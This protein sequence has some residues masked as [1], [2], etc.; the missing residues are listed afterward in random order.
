MVYLYPLTEYREGK[1]KFFRIVILAASFALAS[2]ASHEPKPPKTQEFFNTL[3]K[4]DGTKQFSYAM[5]MEMPDGG[6]QHE[7]GR[8]GGPRGGHGGH[9]GGPPP[10]GGSHDHPKGDKHL[11]E[12]NS[13]D[14][15]LNFTFNESL[16]AKLSDTGFCQQGYKQLDKRSRRG[17]IQLTGECNDMATD[18][19][20]I[21]FPNPPPVKVKEEVIQ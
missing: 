15:H 9:F 4:R 21:K 3:I 2:C 1:V 16:L 14:D 13:M 12:E 6:E 20:K 7:G 5:T 8:Y 10:G 18:G 11:D 19:D 17:V